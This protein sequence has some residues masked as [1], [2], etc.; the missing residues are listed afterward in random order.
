MLDSTM[1]K[2]VAAAPIN[3]ACTSVIALS[4]NYA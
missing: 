4:Y 3:A 2:A 1:T